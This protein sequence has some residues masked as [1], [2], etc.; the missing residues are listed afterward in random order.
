MRRLPLLV[1]LL[2]VL[3]GAW[4]ATQAESVNVPPYSLSIVNVIVR[5]SATQ[6]NVAKGLYLKGG[7]VLTAFHVGEKFGNPTRYLSSTEVP[8][9]ES[10]QMVDDQALDFSLLKLKDAA[11]GG[12]FIEYFGGFGSTELQPGDGV[13]YFRNTSQSLVEN[14]VIP[15]KVLQPRNQAGRILI[16]GGVPQGYSGSPVFSLKSHKL[17][18]MIVFG[19]S[20]MTELCPIE[21]ILDRVR[22]VNSQTLSTI[23]GENQAGP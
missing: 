15:E 4:S 14:E 8:Q 11:Q 16:T 9:L 23:T 2:M 22:Q 12:R 13:Y 19:D 20:T 17:V 6:I 1:I 21:N 5:P 18:G 7:Y 3:L 10:M